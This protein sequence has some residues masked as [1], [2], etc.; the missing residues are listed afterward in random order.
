MNAK[1]GLAIQF[2]QSN[3]REPHN[4]VNVFAAVITRVLDAEQGLVNLSY[5]PDG[6]GWCNASAV[7]FGTGGYTWANIS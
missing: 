3:N 2:T 7:P 1:L 4:G 5:L 6:S